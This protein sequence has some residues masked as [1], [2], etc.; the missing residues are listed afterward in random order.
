MGIFIG[1][2]KAISMGISMTIWVGMRELI[3]FYR[4]LCHVYLGFNGNIINIWKSYGIPM[5]IEL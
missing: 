1:T 5:G 4:I 3:E 2:L